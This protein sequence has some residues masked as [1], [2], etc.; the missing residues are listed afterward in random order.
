[1]T[2]DMSKQVNI[3]IYDT[4]TKQTYFSNMG[5]NNSPIIIITPGSGRHFAKLEDLVAHMGA[6]ENYTLELEPHEAFGEHDP[7]AVKQ[8]PQSDV[9]EELL[10]VGQKVKADTSNN[11]EIEGVVI[12]IADE[13][14]V[15]DF[16]HPLA[17]KYL[18]I[19]VECLSHDS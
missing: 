9:P 12:D 6:G 16:N 1:M 14:A 11:Q 3:K 7:N 18:S 4:E 17:G 13:H 2:K 8:F 15:I 19:D 10:E 5:S